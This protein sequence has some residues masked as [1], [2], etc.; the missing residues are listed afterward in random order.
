MLINTVS[1]HLVDAA[2]LT[3]DSRYYIDAICRTPSN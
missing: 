1:G 2:I 3:V